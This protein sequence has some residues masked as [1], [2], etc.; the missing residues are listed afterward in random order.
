MPRTGRMN[1]M[2]NTQSS[3]GSIW[4]DCANMGAIKVEEK[5]MQEAMTDLIKKLADNPAQFCNLHELTECKF[6]DASQVFKICPTCI[7]FQK[8]SIPMIKGENK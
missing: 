2:D 8:M 3:N 6:K 4:L 5:Y 7:Y 1:D